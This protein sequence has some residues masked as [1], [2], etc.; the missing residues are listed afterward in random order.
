MVVP[1]FTIWDTTKILYFEKNFKMKKMN[2]VYTFQGNQANFTS[3]IFSHYEFALE[4]IKKHKL[5]GILTEYPLDYPIYEWAIDNG[6]FKPK[7]D[8]HTN[9]SFI[10]HFTSV[11]QKHWHFVNGNTE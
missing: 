7:N 10:G 11:R 9:S 5:S 6:Y 3:A 8:H 2:M 1:K 4:W